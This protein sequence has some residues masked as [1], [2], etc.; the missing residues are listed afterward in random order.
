[1]NISELSVIERILINIIN[2][3]H[4]IYDI[5]NI[6]GTLYDVGP[7]LEHYIILYIEYTMI[8]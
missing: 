2:R 3:K 1:M 8:I 4:Y 5:V 7:L 6:A